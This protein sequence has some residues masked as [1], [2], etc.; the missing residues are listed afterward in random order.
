M[1]VKVQI[2]ACNF[3][4][5][6]FIR[7]E[8]INDVWKNLVLIWPQSLVHTNLLHMQVRWNSFFLM[9]Y[10][11]SKQKNI[12]MMKSGEKK[13]TQKRSK[14]KKPIRG[15]M[16]FKTVMKSYKVKIK[17]KSFYSLKWVKYYPNLIKHLKYDYVYLCIFC[18]VPAVKMINLLVFTILKNSGWQCE[19]LLMTAGGTL[20]LLWHNST[21][22][23]LSE[24]FLVFIFFI[25]IVRFF[26]FCFLWN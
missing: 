17:I 14:K 18:I 10:S 6:C 23:G 12:G 13:K 8:K 19:S 21:W 25:C 9:Q 11:L 5:N 7:I 2:K 4:G 16:E 3:S 26:F 24:L 15:K 20:C 22:G 1:Y